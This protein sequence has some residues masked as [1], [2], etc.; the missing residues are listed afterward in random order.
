MEYLFMDDYASAKVNFIKCLEEE[1]ED[2]ASLYNAIYCFEYLEE[3]DEAIDFLNQ[4]LESNPY[5]EVAWHQLGKQFFI[6]SM[7]K[8]ALA[9]FDFAIISDDRFIGAYF[10][11][12]KFSKNLNAIMKPSRIMKSPWGWKTLHPLP[13]FVSENVMKN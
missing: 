12:E 10:E 7:Y 9:S 3:H 5:C 4:Y 2:Y 1:P 11:K 6:K 13:I 8:E